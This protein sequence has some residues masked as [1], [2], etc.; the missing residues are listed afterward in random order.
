MTVAQLAERLTQEELTCWSA[1]FEL[2]NEQEQKIRDQAQTKSRA[3]S[4]RSR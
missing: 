4:G 2:R 3:T 1:Y